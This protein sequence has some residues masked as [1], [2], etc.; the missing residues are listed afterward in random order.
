MDALLELGG[1]WLA[2]LYSVYG[3][4]FLLIPGVLFAYVQPPPSGR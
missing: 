3:F 2:R 1:V 4:L